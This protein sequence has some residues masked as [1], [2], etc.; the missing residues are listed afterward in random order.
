VFAALHVYLN[1]ILADTAHSIPGGKRHYAS[2]AA[3][4]APCDPLDGGDRRR[5]VFETKFMLPWSFSEEG[6]GQKIHAA[7]PAQYV[8]D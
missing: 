7:A 5:A 6:R 4:P 1:A 8:G 3:G 2:A